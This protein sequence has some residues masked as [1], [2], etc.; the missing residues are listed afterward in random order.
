MS[1]RRHHHPGYSHYDDEIKQPTRGPTREE[2][3]VAEMAR[4]RNIY[5]PGTDEAVIRRAAIAE[6]IERGEY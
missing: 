5:R 6:L 2:L 1:E 4:Q 3:V